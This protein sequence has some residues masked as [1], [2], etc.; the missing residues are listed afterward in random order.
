M[1]DRFP[2]VGWVCDNCFA[3]LHE[4]DGFDDFE[5][6]WSCTECG[7]TNRISDED[8]YESTEDYLASDDRKRNFGDD[9]LPLSYSYDSNSDDTDDDEDDDDNYE[10][11]DNYTSGNST[12]RGCGCLGCF[13]SFLNIVKWI[14]IIVIIII[15]LP[16]VLPII[17]DL[18]S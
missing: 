6:Y 17:L 16:F 8:I 2:G 4:Q 13:N 18:F 15:L 1:D 12:G 10:I 3:V 5:D 14:F 11:V 7:Y 9:G